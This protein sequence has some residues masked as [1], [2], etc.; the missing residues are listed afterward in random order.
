MGYAAYNEDCDGKRERVS[1][2][3]GP[4]SWAAIKAASTLWYPELYKL[5]DT[6]DEDEFEAWKQDF[7]SWQENPENY[8]PEMLAEL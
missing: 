6:L 5:T 1:C 3:Y 8:A 2:K 7:Y 4:E